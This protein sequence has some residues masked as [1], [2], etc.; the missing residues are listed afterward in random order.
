M[1]LICSSEEVRCRRRG[2]RRDRPWEAVSEAGGENMTCLRECRGEVDSKAQVG[3]RWLSAVRDHDS[4]D[5]VMK[6]RRE[7]VMDSTVVE[8]SMSCSSLC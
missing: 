1:V 5:E 2:L 7:E 8:D 6:T 4:D 3:L